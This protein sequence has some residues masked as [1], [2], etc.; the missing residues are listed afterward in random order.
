MSATV[1]TKLYV[2]L[3]RDAGVAPKRL[4]QEARWVTLSEK[5]FATLKRQALHRVRQLRQRIRENAE[6]VRTL[7]KLGLTVPIHGA[8]A[9]RRRRTSVEDVV[10][11]E[12]AHVVVAVA[13]GVSVLAAYADVFAA[14][15]LNDGGLLLTHLAHAPRTPAVW[16]DLATVGA[17]GAAAVPGT[18]SATDARL[19]LAGLPNPGQG[20]DEAIAQAE[21]RART[22]LK[23]HAVAVD[24]V[25]EALLRR[26]VLGR[27]ELNRILAPWPALVA[28]EPDEAEIAQMR[29]W[30]GSVRA[31]QQQVA[32][33]R[34]KVVGTRR[35]AR[36]RAT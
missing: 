18:L 33:L 5:A 4:A 31:M 14:V 2:R 1:S 28:R 22:I 9:A 36:R 16:K 27:A 6:L 11:H 24:A 13:L 15:A 25:A 17:A 12:A 8:A 29:L 20:A 7:R 21:K 26:K 3:C 10:R 35:P 34:R 23:R 30:G 19:I 32:T